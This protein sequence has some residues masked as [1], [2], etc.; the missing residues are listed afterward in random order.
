MTPHSE[1]QALSHGTHER[2]IRDIFIYQLKK[3][4]VAK[5]KIIPDIIDSAGAVEVYNAILASQTECSSYRIY[6]H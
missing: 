4:E 5:L 1:Y 3:I 2:E 6:I